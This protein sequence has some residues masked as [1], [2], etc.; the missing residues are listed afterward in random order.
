MLWTIRDSFPPTTSLKSHLKILPFHVFTFLF[1]RIFSLITLCIGYNS[2]VYKSWC[3]CV[4][5]CVSLY[6]HTCTHYISLHRIISFCGGELSGSFNF[7]SQH[8]HDDLQSLK[9]SSIYFR[10]IR[11]TCFPHNI[12]NSII[13][14]FILFS[15][16]SHR[17]YCFWGQRV[18][19]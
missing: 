12:Q 4:C 11:D 13:P 19:S 8:L 18:C 10:V 9:K 1:F 5:V 7:F 14:S 17:T 3:V 6:T 2:S 16:S 15:A